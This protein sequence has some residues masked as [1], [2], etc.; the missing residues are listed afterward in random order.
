MNHIKK[1]TREFF[2]KS[3]R[4]PTAEENSS[5]ADFISDDNIPEQFRVTEYYMLK[6]EVESILSTLTERERTIL[7]LR[8]G[9]ADGK[10]WTL[11]EVG[12]VYHVT[13]ERI[14]QIESRAIRR[15][16]CRRSLK[17]LRNYIE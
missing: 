16:R 11:E 7:K 6:E 8:F 5:L 1:G 17:H 14:R 15:L 13:R 12:K 4:E 9:F 10:I 2:A 3:G